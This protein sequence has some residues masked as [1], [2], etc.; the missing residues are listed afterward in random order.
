MAMNTLS[1]SLGLFGWSWLHLRYALSSI[2]LAATSGFHSLS[3]IHGFFGSV[4]LPLQRGCSPPPFLQMA[5]NTY[6]RAIGT[7]YSKAGNGLPFSS[8]LLLLSLLWVLF[9]IG[10]S[11][12]LKFSTK[13][14]NQLLR[15]LASSW[16]IQYL[17]SHSYVNTSWAISHLLRSM[18]FP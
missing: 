7:V 1:L 11:C 2:T 5:A 6:S 13:A 8:R 3:W 4:G 9:C 17:W 14:N 18:L 10:P 15:R 16:T 12:T